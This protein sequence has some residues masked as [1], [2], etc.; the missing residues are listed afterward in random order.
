M[1]YR[2][3]GEA[4][5]KEIGSNV[6]LNVSG[7][8]QA[9]CAADIDNDG[10]RVLGTDTRPGF[11]ITHDAASAPARARRLDDLLPGGLS[12]TVAAP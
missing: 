8:A 7:W 6:G 11:A 4:R 1:L 3:E 12:P 2:N 9:V 5:F 10:V